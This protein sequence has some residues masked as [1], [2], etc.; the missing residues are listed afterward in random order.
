MQWWLEELVYSFG[1][2]AAFVAM[3]VAWFAVTHHRLREHQKTL[4]QAQFNMSMCS[5]EMLLERETPRYVIAARGG[6]T[7]PKYNVAFLVLG[8]VCAL[9]AAVMPCVRYGTWDPRRWETWACL[10]KTWLTMCVLWVVVG[11]TTQAH[12]TRASPE[13]SQRITA[14]DEDRATV[15]GFLTKLHAAYDMRA[16]EKPQRISGIVLLSQRL[17]SRIARVHACTAEEAAA[18]YNQ[19]V[20]ENTRELFGYLSFHSSAPDVAWLTELAARMGKD[21]KLD[22]IEQ[23]GVKKALV[24][25]G[26]MTCKEPVSDTGVVLCHELAAI[27]E[28]SIDGLYG[29][30]VFLLM[31]ALAWPYHGLYQLLADGGAAGTV[32]LTLVFLGAVVAVM[33]AGVTMRYV[34]ST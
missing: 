26:S 8:A 7:L 23:A 32:V 14:Y 5:A 34:R 16:A 20:A 33:I 25:L 2:Q 6:L 29:P 21:A 22:D 24:R 1:F 19:L 9:A 4:V 28:R 30:S 3:V 10:N 15:A 12:Y 18:R 27:S 11:G 31:L 17:V 13:M